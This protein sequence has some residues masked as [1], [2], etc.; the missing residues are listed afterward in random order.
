GGHALAAITLSTIDSSGAA[1]VR[2]AQTAFHLQL[3]G[4]VLQ[5][6]TLAF[7]A[8]RSQRLLLESATPLSVPPRLTVGYRPESFV[9]LAEG[10]GPYRLAAGSARARHG[11]YP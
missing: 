8:P 6:D 4:Q 3:D 7:T 5:N 11:A 10:E 1:R 2:A 9:F